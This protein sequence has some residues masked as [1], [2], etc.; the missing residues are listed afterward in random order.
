MK[1]RIDTHI[2]SSKVPH[3]TTGN[4][5]AGPLYVEVRRQDRIH[6][7]KNMPEILRKLEVGNFIAGMEAIAEGWGAR[8]P[9]KQLEGSN[10]VL[11]KLLEARLDEINARLEGKRKDGAVIKFLSDAKHPKAEYVK[12]AK[13]ELETLKK[14]LKTLP[15]DK[16]L[17]TV[18]GVNVRHRI[19]IAEMLLASLSDE[20][21]KDIPKVEAPLEDIEVAVNRP[22]TEFEKGQQWG[23]YTA[24]FFHKKTR[25]RLM[26]SEIKSIHWAFYTDKGN[27]QIILV[28]SKFDPDYKNT[29]DEGVARLMELPTKDARGR[30]EYGFVRARPPGKATGAEPLMTQ[31][32]EPIRNKEGKYEL[33]FRVTVRRGPAGELLLKPVQEDMTPEKLDLYFRGTLPDVNY[34]YGPVTGTSNAMVVI[35]RKPRVEK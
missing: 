28:N 12:I 19:A 17:F 29:V 4:Y 8:P 21:I 35:R 26:T 25:K 22:G 18:H 13:R 27:G 14:D 6:Y 1:A 33:L 5:P 23:M 15:A 32:W 3:E 34:E 2:D 30:P 9:K 7:D 31:V 20:N 10:T 24:N 16:D 11:L